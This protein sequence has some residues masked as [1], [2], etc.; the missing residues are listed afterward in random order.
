MGSSS[1]LRDV[2]SFVGV[3]GLLVN[4]RQHFFNMSPDVDI[5]LTLWRSYAVYF[6]ND[7]RQAEVVAEIER[8]AEE[9]RRAYRILYPVH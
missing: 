3:V 8:L 9:T 4:S 7:E 6:E 2:K 1:T 5:W